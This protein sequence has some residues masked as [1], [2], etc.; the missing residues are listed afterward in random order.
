MEYEH[1]FKV[2][3]L[4]LEARIWIRIR[5]KVKG[6]IRQVKSDKQDPD[7]YQSDKQD[8]DMFPQGEDADPT[9]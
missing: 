2:F 1:F 6:R 4:Y 5:V 8:L 9:H 3:S 7:P